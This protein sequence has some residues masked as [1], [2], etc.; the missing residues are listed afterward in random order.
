V[1]PGGL[2]GARSL[3]VRVFRGGAR[4][5]YARRDDHIISRCRHFGI[6]SV[7]VTNSPDLLDPSI[8]RQIAFLFALKTT[9]KDDL[10]TLGRAALVD[11]ASLEAYVAHMPERHCLM[12][13]N[14]TRYP[15]MAPAIS[16]VLYPRR[17]LLCCFGQISTSIMDRGRR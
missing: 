2:V 17:V 4:L 5:L 11:Q 10:R 1:R 9:S 8:F 6:A 13:G 7:F 14:V 15:M 3:A 16:A 12:I